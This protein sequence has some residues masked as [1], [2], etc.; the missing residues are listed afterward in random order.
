[1]HIS[2]LIAQS[3]ERVRREIRGPEAP[4]RGASQPEADRR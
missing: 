2:R 1:M 3:L 4:E